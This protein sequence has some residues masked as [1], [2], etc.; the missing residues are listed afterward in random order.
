MM[1]TTPASATSP[2]ESL[3]MRLRAL[4]LPTFARLAPEVAQKA[5]R[6]GWSFGQ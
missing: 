6:E 4:K 3:G 1:A 5:E 2:V